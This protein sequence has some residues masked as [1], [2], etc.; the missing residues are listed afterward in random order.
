MK[1]F[2]V[3]QASCKSGALHSVV[4]V[5]T[6][7]RTGIPLQGKPEAGQVVGLKSSSIG[8][9][10]PVLEARSASLAIFLLNLTF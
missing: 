4:V 7:K 3:C 5:V 9:A 1:S 6:G 10:A 8:G 2:K